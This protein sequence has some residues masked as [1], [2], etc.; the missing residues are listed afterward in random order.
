[1]S[2]AV[3]QINGFAA[4]D[5]SDFGRSQEIDTSAIQVTTAKPKN[6]RRGGKVFKVGDFKAPAETHEINFSNMLG[7]TD[8]YLE[9]AKE[10]IN[11]L[12]DQAMRTIQ[13][14]L[15]R[16]IAG[17]TSMNVLGPVF[18]DEFYVRL[19][20]TQ[21]AFVKESALKSGK[22]EIDGVDYVLNPHDAIRI[23]DVICGPNNRPTLLKD[24]KIDSLGEKLQRVVQERARSSL[25]SE[26]KLKPDETYT[27]TAWLFLAY[28]RTFRNRQEPCRFI[29][30]CWDS[31]GTTPERLMSVSDYCKRVDR[32]PQPQQKNNNHSRMR[33]PNQVGTLPPQ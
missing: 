3:P 24:H 22:A 9:L 20:S 4:L 5:E 14:R 7:N 21:W 29:S 30:M 16:L 28:R 26:G 27:P 15:D 8:H 18:K 25:I 33:K 17:T 6:E 13:Y 19:S 2:E 10:A 23:W 12:C 32:R 1:M 11:C 31:D